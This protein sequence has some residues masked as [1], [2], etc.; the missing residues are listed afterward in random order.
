MK[1]ISVL[2]L[3]LAVPAVLAVGQEVA[4]TFVPPSGYVDLSP[5]LDDLDGDGQLDV[6]VVSTNGLTA[7]LDAAGAELWRHEARGRICAPPTVADITGTPSPEVLVANVQGQIYCLDGATGSVVWETALA[8]RLEYATSALAAGDVDGDGLPEVV[9]ADREGAVICLNDNGEQ[10]WSSA[11]SLGV[12]SCP[13]LGDLNGDG[14]LEILIGGTK[15]ALVCLSAEGKELWRAE[16]GAGGSPTLCDLDKD[17]ALDIL[18]GVDAALTAFDAQGKLLWSFPMQREMDSALSVADADSDGE[19]EVYAVDLAGTAVCVTPNGQKRW[20]ASVGERVRRSPS[21]GDVD[22]D[23]VVEILIAGYSRALYVFDPEGSLELRIP[24]SGVSNGTPTLLQTT[25][26]GLCAIV[27]TAQEALQVLSWPKTAAGA[28]LL[29]PEYRF[30]SRRMANLSSGAQTPSVEVEADFGEFHAGANVFRVSVENPEG[31]AL[32]MRLEAVHDGGEPVTSSGSTSATTIKRE[33][34]YSVPLNKASNLTLTCVVSEGDRILARRSRSAYLVPLA[35]EL[36]DLDGAVAGLESRMPA[37]LDRSGLEERACLL[38]VRVDGVREKVAAAGAMENTARLALRDQLAALLEE[39]A[40]LSGML[41]AAEEATASGSPLLVRSANPWAPF[42][43][44][45]DLTSG[46]GGAPALTVE[47]FGGETESAALDL[48]N[49][50]GTARTFRVMLEGLQQG[51]QTVIPKDA[52]TLHEVVEV[53][54]EMRDLSADALPLLNSANTIMVPAWGG[55]RLWLNLRTHGLAP[56]EWSGRVV[57]RSLDVEPVNSE[58]DLTVTVW[59]VRVPDKQAL[60]LCH[61]GYVHSSCLKEYPEAAL[62]DQV[63]HGT[64]VFVGLFYPKAEFDAQGN[65]V[66]EIDFRQHDDYVKQHAPHGR[67]LFFNYQ[68]ALKGP[69]PVESEAYGKAHVAWLRAWVA[70]LAEL[71]VTYDGFALYPIDEPGLN[72]G[73]VQSYIRMAQLAR[74]ADPKI[75]L[76]TDPVGRISEEELR[77]MTPYVDIWCPNRGGFI[78][79]QSNAAKFDLI[80][81][82]GKTVWTY[83][84]DANVKHQSPLGYYRAQAWLAWD[85]GLTGIGFWSYCTSQDD[86]WFQ[87]TLRHDYLLV[88]PGNGVV[89]SVRWEAV[90][91]G[92]EDYNLLAALKRAAGN[93]PASAKREDLEAAKALLGTQATAL[94]QFCG[95]DADGTQPG[96]QGTPGVQRVEDARWAAYQQTRREMARLLTALISP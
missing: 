14:T 16:G 45:S 30:D 82:T 58:A 47:A 53:P 79:D 34:S 19:L 31:R 22:G 91:D 66:G 65:L 70:H 13:A 83:E 29:W 64:N 18:A 38:R 32:T 10:A 90:R 40:S 51:E 41:A 35:R 27:P 15:A 4:W 3:A 39:A 92:V 46:R 84:C 93:P 8:S 80:K 96:E 42:T 55:R 37:L 54:T 5:G 49:A 61:W 23:G 25:P 59:P 43:G 75:V 17:G 88:Y 21:I 50:S 68:H 11:A 76:Y 69:A 9:L 2:V 94:A 56:G 52:V 7:A 85:R 48:Y 20:T 87:P 33:L 86:P 60:S 28:P 24:L 1:R 36:A 72:D 77:A 81:A 44:F 12:P 89:S 74:E 57:L 67:I 6:V 78:V 26:Q 62:D 73:L 63:R 71:G 95:L